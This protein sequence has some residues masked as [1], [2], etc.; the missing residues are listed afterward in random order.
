MKH[1]VAGRSRVAASPLLLRG[2]GVSQGRSNTIH[3]LSTAACSSSWWASP[4]GARPPVEPRGTGNLLEASI[5]SGSAQNA[6]CDS[7][8][9]PGPA[10]DGD[11]RVVAF[12]VTG[13][14]KPSSARW[15][16]SGSW[17]LALITALGGACYATARWTLPGSTQ[18][19]ALLLPGA[20][21]GLLAVDGRASSPGFS[22]GSSALDA[23]GAGGVLGTGGE[24]GLGRH[25]NLLAVLLRPCS[26]ASAAGCCAMCWPA[27]YRCPAPGDLRAGESGRHS[28]CSGR[29]TRP[30]PTTVAPLAPRPDP[31]PPAGRHP[32]GLNL[33]AQG[34]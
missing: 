33:P 24:V 2:R 14:S 34:R 17:F 29:S 26:P 28:P 5:P 20:A 15:T 30:A 12:A 21:G 6:S 31:R 25:L 7:A 32:L 16:C 23:R 11:G 19:P 1:R 18:H 8:A 4:A 3:W 13:R 10:G 27:R 22:P 9:R